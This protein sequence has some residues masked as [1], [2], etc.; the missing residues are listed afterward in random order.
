[1]DKITNAEKKVFLESRG[2]HT[3]YHH[4]YWVDPSLKVGDYTDWGFNLDQAYEHETAK[5]TP[6]D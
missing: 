1:M 6:N 5:G 2:W 4:D 3:W